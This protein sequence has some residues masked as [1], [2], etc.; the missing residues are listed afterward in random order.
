MYVNKHLM[1]YL[2]NKNFCVAFSVNK[3][4]LKQNKPLLCLVFWF[5]WCLVVEK[6]IQVLLIENL[7]VRVKQYLMCSEFV[8]PKNVLLNVIDKFKR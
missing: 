8:T 1:M 4:Y 5:L 2:C 7:K 3:Q 6:R